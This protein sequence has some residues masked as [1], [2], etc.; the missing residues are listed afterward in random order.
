MV[1][2]VDLG[3]GF[4][5]FISSPVSKCLYVSGLFLACFLA[6]EM[7]EGNSGPASFLKFREGR[8][9]DNSGF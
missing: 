6:R 9:N 8:K 1:R 3:S 5:W 7:G 2:A 4:L